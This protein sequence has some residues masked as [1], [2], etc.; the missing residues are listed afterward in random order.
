MGVGGAAVVA[1]AGARRVALR[2][3][4]GIDRERL[5]TNTDSLNRW[6]EGGGM[7]DPFL[8]ISA[9]GALHK[10]EASPES[11]QAGFTPFT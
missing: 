5:A 3:T 11:D 6:A 8:V 4:D 2:D 10:A 1:L 9:Q 7:T